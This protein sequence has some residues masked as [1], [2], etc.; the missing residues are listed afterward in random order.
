MAPPPGNR[1]RQCLHID[2]FSK[3]KT[4]YLIY[5]IASLGR[6]PLFIDV[7]LWA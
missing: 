4:S 1:K 5:E 7:K 2:A 6:L 3:A